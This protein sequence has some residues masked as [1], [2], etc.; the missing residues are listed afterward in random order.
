MFDNI[1]NILSLLKQKM[2]EPVLNRKAAGRLAAIRTAAADVSAKQ[3]NALELVE[4][5]RNPD[6]VERLIRKYG[7]NID[8]LRAMMHAGGAYDDMLVRLIETDG[9]PL[10]WEEEG[11]PLLMLALSERHVPSIEVILNKAVENPQIFF[12]P[13]GDGILPLQALIFSGAPL[14]QILQVLELAPQ[15]VNATADAMKRTPLM[16]A[17]T[18]PSTQILDFLCQQGAVVNAQMANGRT[19]LHIATAAS[20]PYHV[21]TLLRRGA[22]VDIAD[23][24]G[25]T[26][27]STLV[28]VCHNAN[29][30]Q[31]EE[32]FEVAVPLVEEHYRR[33][34]GVVVSSVLTPMCGAVASAILLAA[35]ANGDVDTVEEALEVGANVDKMHPQTHR[36]ALHYAV[37]RNNHRMVDVLFRKGTLVNHPHDEENVPMLA[38]QFPAMHDRLNDRFADQSMEVEVPVAAAAAAAGLPIVPKSAKDMDNPCSICQEDDPA[39]VEQNGPFEYL[40]PCGH[41]MHS[42]CLSDWLAHAHGTLKCPLCQQLVTG[43]WVNG[44]H[45][46]GSRRSR[47]SRSGKAGKAGKSWLYISFMSASLT[48]KSSRKSVKKS[49][50]PVKTSVK[51][52]VKK[53]R[54]SVK[55]SV[56]NSVKS[57]KKSSKKLRKS[58]KKLKKS[59]KSVKK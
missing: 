56:K 24:E 39:S 51:K 27:L 43:K 14:G 40:A 38:A 18:N 20:L 16:M 35:A 55:T 22:K 2:S 33:G 8:T 3:N 47:R 53:S 49:R 21:R 41:R 13:N 17:I 30:E 7:A 12:A 26:P 37:E 5:R 31:K 23:N 11:Q 46:F 52:S 50:K 36:R 15:A 48:K 29:P 34:E 45:A 9:I 19:A 28:E 32:V 1:K 54:K 10:T 4:S 6:E 25:N 44:G 57:S 42:K 59:R 58:V